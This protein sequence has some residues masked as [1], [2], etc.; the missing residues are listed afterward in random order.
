MA[1]DRI[2]PWANTTGRH[3]ATLEAERGLR[4]M[5]EMTDNELAALAA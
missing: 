5:V 4:R 2:E 3:T 1:I